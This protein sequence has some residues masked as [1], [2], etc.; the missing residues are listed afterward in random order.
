MFHRKDILMILIIFLVNTTAVKN[1]LIREKR[2]TFSSA[3]EL[4]Q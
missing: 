2:Q 3:F 1:I 4:Y